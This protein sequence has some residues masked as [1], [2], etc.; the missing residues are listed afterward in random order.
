MRFTFLTPAIRHPKSSRQFYAI[1]SLRRRLRVIAER[2]SHGGARGD[3]VVHRQCGR[4]EAYQEAVPR[5]KPTRKPK[6]AANTAVP[7]SMAAM[8]GMGPAANN[9]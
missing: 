2:K 8:V 3:R 5:Q 9:P 6:V 1:P 4:P 7:P